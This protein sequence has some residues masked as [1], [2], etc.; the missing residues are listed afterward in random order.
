MLEPISYEHINIDNGF[1]QQRQQLNRD[2]TVRS[3][4][5][6]FDKTGRIRAFRFDWTPD[7][8]PAMKPHIF[9]D[10]DV[11]KWMEGA[12][13]IIAKQPDPELEAQVDALVEQIA[14][15]QGPDGYFNI[16]YT[17]IEPENRFTDRSKH[18]LY[19]AGHLIEAA[20]AYAQAT[21]KTKLLDC[22]CRYADLI[23]RV[24][25]QTKSA[26][27]LTP[28]HEEIELALVRLADYTGEKRYLDLARWFIDMRGMHPEIDGNS[29]YNQS[30][31]PVRQQHTAE[32]HAVR[33]GY[34]YCAMADLALRDD[35]SELADSC[36][37]IFDNITRRRMYI[38]GGIGS[39][40]VEEA[41][42]IDYDL[43]N[44]HAYAE[45]CAAIS[46]A[47][48][49]QRML[50]LE[51]D[52]VYADTVERVLYNGFLSSTS[53]DGKSFFYENPL[54]IRPALL[55]RHHR[56]PNPEHFPITQRVEVFSCSCC[57]PN[58]VRFVA[59]LGGMLY[60]T[61]EAART[62]YVHQYI[63][64]NASFDFCGEKA[65][66]TLETNY[67]ADGKIRLIWNGPDCTL[68]LRVPGWV[69]GFTEPTEHG[70][71]HRTATNGSVIEL[72][73]P[74]ETALIAANPHVQTDSGRCAVMRGPVVYCMESVDNGG[75][76]RDI[77]LI[78]DGRTTVCTNSVCGLPVL[79]MDAERRIP[80]D[81]LYSDRR[82]QLFKPFRAKLIPYFAFA[83]RGESEM[84]VWS[85]IHA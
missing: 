32:G 80:T 10:S 31:L 69:R 60:A 50:R 18:E 37:T 28:G 75:D 68:A 57:P 44:L 81:T 26:A 24:F 42:T 48:F 78:P 53:L 72:D 63:H 23:D 56:T 77:R 25:R 66:L 16:Y 70:Y 4:Y 13:Y 59:S 33:A 22:M 45:S 34:L 84:L 43:N 29:I 15:H 79:E 71:L 6:Q 2:V 54:E 74:M 3:V 58:I 47:M 64:S 11:A 5:R 8:D 65:H 12:A 14:A 30:H 49:S 36:R 20:V 55:H 73:F 17:V 67:P 39:T 9:W 51:P 1:W 82:D 41:F 46:L 62:V 35:D 83:N 19:C 61:D 21:G 76:L 7:M 27:F 38:T 52:S 40:S 85:L